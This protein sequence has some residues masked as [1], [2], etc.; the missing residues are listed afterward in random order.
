MEKELQELKEKL[1]AIS[2]VYKLIDNKD[3]K[4]KL[5]ELSLSLQK[6]ILGEE[7]DKIESENIYLR[8]T[9]ERIIKEPTIS[10]S[11]LKIS[12]IQDDFK[13]WYSIHYGKTTPEIIKLLREF[14][15]I[16]FGK[17]PQNGWGH[18]SLS[19]EEI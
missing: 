1:N 4:I 2:V 10:G 3:L 17:Y 18:I 16:K 7:E 6:Q 9:E 15:V 8:Y 19:E 12:T 11:R 14:L 13:E 5:L